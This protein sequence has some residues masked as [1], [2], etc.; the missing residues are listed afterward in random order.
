MSLLSV[1][2]VC[3][4]EDNGRHL[5]EHETP[6]SPPVDAAHARTA[7]ATGDLQLKLRD[8]LVGADPDDMAQAL[9]REAIPHPP[10]FP[11]RGLA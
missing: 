5:L 1:N 11:L 9:C 10:R 7:R 8:L 3:H 6:R 2:N 4:H